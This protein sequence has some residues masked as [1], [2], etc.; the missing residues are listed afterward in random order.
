MTKIMDHPYNN[1]SREPEKKAESGSLE[2][3]T[4]A[5]D[6]TFRYSPKYG[7][8]YVSPSS[9]I[10]TGYDPE[11]YY[12][13]HK[14]VLDI[15][16]P[17][18]RAK[19]KK[20]MEAFE[21]HRKPDQPVEVRWLH[22]NGHIVY[23]EISSLPIY[24]DQ[25]LIAIESV[26]RDVTDRKLVTRIRES[27]L[28][29]DTEGQE[30]TDTIRKLNEAITERLIRKI[31]QIDHISEIREEL[32]TSSNVEDGLE[33]ILEGASTDLEADV[34]A[35]FSIDKE[36]RIIE[37]RIQKSKMGIQIGRRYSLDDSFLE[38]ECLQVNSTVSRVV[39]QGVSI[40]GTRSVHCS[41]VTVRDQMIGLLA[42]GNV[43]ERVL[44]QSDI[45][46]LRLYSGLI[47]TVFETAYSPAGSIK[48]KPTLDKIQHRLD[49]GH[50]YATL[51]DG[52]LAFETFEEHVMNGMQG[53]CITTVFPKEIRRRYRLEKTP[54]AWLSNQKVRDQFVI[55]NIHELSILITDY[56]RNNK[57]SL[58]L[59]DGIDYLISNHGFEPVH[60]FLLSKRC[61]IESSGSILIIPFPK[62]S[63]NP[64][65]MILIMRE[66]EEYAR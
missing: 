27:L 49:F 46:T 58:V 30:Q 53:L 34:A 15:I 3:M 54:I 36:R 5:G 38:S 19:I 52:N 65:E 35:Y 22:K 9:S 13:N 48:S 11:E 18:D 4:D 6:M 47:S 59:I 42:L 62:S 66:F 64:E 41:P 7:F 25:N 23:V 8:E 24:D 43:D 32:K 56:L 40:L 10:V 17:E 2:S 12:S 39:G 21:D 57:K 37:T 29:L 33:A 31:N 45:S 1:R 50:I 16:H 26:V 44:D 60:H 28:D 51:D 20:L 61:E 63:L 14:T 55:D